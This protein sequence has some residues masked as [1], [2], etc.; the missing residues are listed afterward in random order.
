MEVVKKHL[1]GLYGTDKVFFD[2]AE[3]LQNKN[4]TIDV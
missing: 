1:V 4:K 2:F 3:I